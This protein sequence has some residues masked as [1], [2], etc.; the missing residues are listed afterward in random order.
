MSITSTPI[1]V[2]FIYRWSFSL[3]RRCYY[4]QED[5][6]DLTHVMF[7][8]WPQSGRMVHFAAGHT[9]CPELLDVLLML[10]VLLVAM[11]VVCIFLCFCNA[12][13]G[14]SRRKIWTRNRAIVENC[15][16]HKL[17]PRSSCVAQI[18]YECIHRLNLWKNWGF[19][20]RHSLMW[21]CRVSFILMITQCNCLIWF[22]YEYRVKYFF[23]IHIR[24]LFPFNATEKR[25]VANLSTQF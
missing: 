1:A 3:F 4:W 13:D 24:Q 11:Q 2:S 14:I 9:I 25:I 12:N 16:V 19:K 5:D 18:R 20:G 22:L 15:Y 7:A 8:L 17:L 10:L 23:V 21:S 6:N